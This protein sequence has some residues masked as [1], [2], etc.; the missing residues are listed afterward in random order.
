MRR[1]NGLIKDSSAEFC[2][3]YELKYQHL[4]N[5]Y[6]LEIVFKQK[7]QSILNIA[8]RGFEICYVFYILDFVEK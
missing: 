8:Q 1:G 5:Y 7:N 4:L 3:R 2:M 6:I